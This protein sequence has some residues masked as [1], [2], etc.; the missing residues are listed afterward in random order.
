MLRII[1]IWLWKYARIFALYECVRRENGIF[2]LESA[3]SWSLGRQE[4]MRVSVFQK[5]RQIWSTTATQ[6]YCL[7]EDT[8]ICE[9]SR[10]ENNLLQVQSSGKFS[11]CPHPGPNIQIRT[12]VECQ[13]LSLTY[14][15]QEWVIPT[16]RDDKTHLWERST[17]M[18]EHSRNIQPENTPEKTGG[19]ARKMSAQRRQSTIVTESSDHIFVDEFSIDRDIICVLSAYNYF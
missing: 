4:E 8:W 6:L 15:R 1:K 3:H 13:I 16:Y 12:F 18:S 2:L 9:T 10:A 19:E 5:Q 11:V 17:K 14:S 7:T